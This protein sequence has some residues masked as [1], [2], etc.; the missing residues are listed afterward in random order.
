M[1]LRHGGQLLQKLAGVLDQ[2]LLGASHR[3]KGLQR[4]L[5]GRSNRVCAV[6]PCRYTT[7]STAGSVAHSTSQRI[8]A[9]KV[10][11]IPAT[12]EGIPTFL[13]KRKN[14]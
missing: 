13:C 9:D 6:G 8:R 3:L 1:H 12:H 4:A 10:L 7:S 2:P 14:A 11:H 5:F